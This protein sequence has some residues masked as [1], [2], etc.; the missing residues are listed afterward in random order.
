MPEKRYEQIKE[1]AEKYLV[2]EFGECAL[3][4]MADGVIDLFIQGALW[5]D[6]NPAQ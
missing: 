2:Q 5:A 3:K 6:A 4:W 1:A